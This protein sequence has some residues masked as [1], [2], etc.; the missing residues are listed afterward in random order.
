MKLILNAWVY[1]AKGLFIN[2]FEQQSYQSEQLMLR[3]MHISCGGEQ[4]HI[5]SIDLNKK[6]SVTPP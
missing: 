3:F 6:G 5:S 1:T 2:N 4:D